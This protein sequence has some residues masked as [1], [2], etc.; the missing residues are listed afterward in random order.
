MFPESKY[1]MLHQG[2][3]QPEAEKKEYTISLI[4]TSRWQQD[5]FFFLTK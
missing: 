3:F 5:F 4:C 2:A 1:Y